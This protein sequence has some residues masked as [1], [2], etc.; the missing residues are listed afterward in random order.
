MMASMVAA[1]SSSSH[2]KIRSHRTRGR[3]PVVGVEVVTINRLHIKHMMQRVL[4]ANCPRCLC[5]VATG[6]GRVVITQVAG[7]RESRALIRNGCRGWIMH[8]IHDMQWRGPVTSQSQCVM[9]VAFAVSN[10][11]REKKWT[12]Y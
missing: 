8:F 7:R 9:H 1:I 10:A 5:R 3:N 11:E 6:H 12:D 2:G 4:A